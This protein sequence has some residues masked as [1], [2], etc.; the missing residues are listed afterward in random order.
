MRNIIKRYVSL[1]NHPVLLYSACRFERVEFHSATNIDRLDCSSWLKQKFTYFI[2]FMCILP[3]SRL[4]LQVGRQH[5]SQFLNL[6]TDHH[7]VQTFDVQFGCYCF[8]FAE[9]NKLDQIMRTYSDC[10]LSVIDTCNLPQ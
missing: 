1:H 2:W 7:F 10:F 5:F 4:F 6:V 8:N 9:T 3:S